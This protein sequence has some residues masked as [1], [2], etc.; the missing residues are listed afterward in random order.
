[1]DKI[2]KFLQTLS[3]KELEAFLLIMK[4]IK[5]DYTK[6]PG[7]K[8]IKAK[9]HLYRVRMGRYRLIFKITKEVIEIVR[10][11]KRDDQTYKNL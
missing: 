8:K 3:K 5:L 2:S 1:M 6:I 7:L 9:N 11:T 10:I 4:Q